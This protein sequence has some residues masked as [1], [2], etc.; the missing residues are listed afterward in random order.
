MILPMQIKTY[1]S[2][3]S[4]N[5]RISSCYSSYSNNYNRLYDQRQ[6]L[7]PGPNLYIAKEIPITS[8]DYANPADNINNN[9]SSFR[10]A[11]GTSGM[12]VS[13]QVTGIRKDPWANVHRVQVEEDKPDKE[14]GFY[15]HPDLYA[16][17]EDK[18][19]SS[20]LF[21]EQKRKMKELLTSE[22]K[23]NF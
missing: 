13:W 19:V 12:K 6:H 20:L 4:L 18:G 8:T 3:P 9:H 17:P 16:Q 23:H 21:P 1:Y 7:A 11:G 10:I 5:N 14:R 22:V 15:M 2:Y